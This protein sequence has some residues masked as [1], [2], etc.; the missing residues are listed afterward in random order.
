MA[1]V[2]KCLKYS[3]FI[4]NFLF[5]VCGCVI[6][7]ISIWLRVSSDAQQKLN[8]QGSGLLSAIDVMIA[9]GA[10]IMVL[11]FFG[12][13]G[14]IKESRCLLLLFFIG[15][16]LIL[17]LQITAG[18]L[19]VVYKPQLEDK[20]NKTLHGLLPLDNQPEE[21]KQAL[22]KIQ[23]E[24]KCCGIVHGIL[25]WRSAIPKSCSCTVPTNPDTCGSGYYKQTCASVFVDYYK[26]H[27]VIIIGIAFGLAAVENVDFAARGFPGGGP[28]DSPKMM[29][30]LQVKENYGESSISHGQSYAKLGTQGRE[31]SRSKK[32]AEFGT[33]GN[34]SGLSTAKLNN[35][36]ARI[37]KHRKYK[38]S[39][40]PT[41]SEHLWPDKAVAVLGSRYSPLAA[42]ATESLGAKPT[43]W[44][45]PSSPS[46]SPVKQRPKLHH[47]TP[48]DAEVSQRTSL[49]SIPSTVK[50]FMDIPTNDSPATGSLMKEMLLA[51]SLSMQK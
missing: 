20:V 25:D 35:L 12:C 24:S 6:L 2:N 7:G 16:F 40:H 23:E 50:S 32:Y 11:G 33:Q 3:M 44:P 36:Q 45:S 10:I 9:V 46:V 34:K 38:A 1:G 30:G 21:F 19:G 48:Q 8:I 43:T 41:A 42:G 18:I 28:Q 5:W 47:Q 22:E 31:V 13:C 15:L 27:L 37:I 29:S 39:S 17:A 49:P 14:A 4:F 26:N 51:F